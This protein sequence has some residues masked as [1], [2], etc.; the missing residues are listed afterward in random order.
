MELSGLSAWI[1]VDS[2]ELTQYNIEVSGNKATCW[3][4][5]ETGKKFT[6]NW[7]DSDRAC[8]LA[9]YVYIDGV[10]CGGNTV[11]P[12]L[13]GCPVTVRKSSIPTSTM[14][15]KPFMFSR[16]EL[17]DD[18]SLLDGVTSQL[19]EISIEI[20]RVAVVSF[21]P[22]HGIYFPEAQKVHEKSKKALAHRVELGDEVFA[23][24]TQFS[25]VAKT[26]YAPLATFTFKYR[27]LGGSLIST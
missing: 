17:T 1:T 25:K 13:P 14:S 22:A 8:Q 3:I 2:T 12:G 15:E 11:P 16:L 23:P 6:L 19:G 18:D 5:S 7:R 21:M 20:W 26:D 27:S 9:G 24:Q 4:P 10:P